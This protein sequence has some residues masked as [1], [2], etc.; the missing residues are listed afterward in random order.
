MPESP[1]PKLNLH[2]SPPT[3]AATMAGGTNNPSREIPRP[4]SGSSNLS[5]KILPGFDKNNCRD[6]LID[7]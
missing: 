1:D 4:H 5:G 6:L 2:Q 3:S 7:T